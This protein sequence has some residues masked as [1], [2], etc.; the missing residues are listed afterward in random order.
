MGQFEMDREL[1]LA[2]TPI[3]IGR[4]SSREPERS[5]G[6]SNMYFKNSHL[7]K[8]HA[9]LT[10]AD[11][12]VFLEDLL[13]TFGTVWNHNLLVPHT[14]V[15]LHEGDVIGF[16]LNR[17]SAFIL[18]LTQKI[19][20]AA[21]VLLSL[22][23]N[24]RVQLSL[25]V[26]ELDVARQ[27][28]VFAPHEEKYG[29]A[30]ADSDLSDEHTAFYVELG[31]ENDGDEN[32]DL[33]HSSND[34][35]DEGPD[36]E[37]IIKEICSPAT[38]VEVVVEAPADEHCE[39]SD[40]GEDPVSHESDDEIVIC[41]LSEKRDDDS[42]DESLASSCADCTVNEST[43]EVSA[44]DD[45]FMKSDIVSDAESECHS[46]CG[47]SP[48]LD[49]DRLGLQRL[50]DALDSNSEGFDT[51]SES[52]DTHSEEEFSENDAACE[53]YCDSECSECEYEVSEGRDRLNVDC[54]IENI[55][56]EKPPRAVE[57]LECGHLAE[58]LDLCSCSDTTT[59]DPE[60]VGEYVEGDYVPSDYFDS[61]FDEEY[62]IP[63]PRGMKRLRDDTEE[64]VEGEVKPAPPKRSKTSAVLKEAG[65]GIL[66]VFG[67]LLAILA[68]GDYL[69]RNGV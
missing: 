18:K 59:V 4:A 69:E 13:S 17:P 34:E 57:C 12:V 36:E 52:F 55:M 53:S 5:A 56:T 15:A 64:E 28:L 48:Q 62:Y 46:C 21:M 6:P 43:T 33:T 38:I 11:G 61:D 16:I 20:P 14:R 40:C 19:H 44:K 63:E 27:R 9:R 29:F 35:S 32:Q 3:P 42:I 39:L 7:S 2:K 8:T 67:T 47:M 65:K 31:S 58:E 54:F 41:E 24:P 1:T 26:A 68:Y 49:G 50:I 51:N 45:S 30:T 22:L 60:R 37:S 23:L 66:Y 25:Q 10:V